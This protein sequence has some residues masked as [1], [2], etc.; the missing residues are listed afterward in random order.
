MADKICPPTKSFPRKVGF[1][2]PESLSVL[3]TPH[4]NQGNVWNGMAGQ[5]DSAF[6][7]SISH[8]D[9]KKPNCNIAGTKKGLPGHHYPGMNQK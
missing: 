5:S 1:N 2:S 4:D 9:R 8:S 6:S 7:S 3:T